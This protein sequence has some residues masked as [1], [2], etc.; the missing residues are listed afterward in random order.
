MARVWP[1]LGELHSAARSAKL[2]PLRCALSALIAEARLIMGT[3]FLSATPC[4]GLEHS[5]TLY[6][7]PVLHHWIRTLLADGSDFVLAEWRWSAAQC[8]LLH[9]FLQSLV[10]PAPWSAS[11]ETLSAAL[12]TVDPAWFAWCDP[13]RQFP[14][15]FCVLFH[16]IRSACHGTS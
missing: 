3:C 14:A 2:S 5:P 1:A 8:Q 6:L 16:A 4:S 12:P 13:P 9:A 7:G 11:A 10:A 15:S